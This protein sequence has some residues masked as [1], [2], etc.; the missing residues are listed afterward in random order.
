MNNSTKNTI[1]EVQNFMF[2]K[3]QLK[4]KTSLTQNDLCLY[5]HFEQTVKYR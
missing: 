1:L 5:K 3:R 2:L 4:E